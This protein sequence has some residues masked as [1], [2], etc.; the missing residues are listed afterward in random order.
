MT[1]RGHTLLFSLHFHIS[2]RGTDPSEG[3]HTPRFARS[4]CP[5]PNSHFIF[6]DDLIFFVEASMDQARSVI[7][8]VLTLFFK[9]SGQKVNL[10][11]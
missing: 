1:R 10:K 8:Q 3:H 2:V 11:K 5:G 9:G 7:K 4:P 6:A